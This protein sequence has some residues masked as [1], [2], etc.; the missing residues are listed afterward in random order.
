MLFAL[1]ALFGD[2]GCSVGP[3]LCGIV[4]DAAA[5]LPVLEQLSLSTGMGMEQ[6]ALKV[7]L[8]V[9]AIF[10]IAAAVV[11]RI[12]DKEGRKNCLYQNRN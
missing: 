11:I 2:V 8:L 4:S 12:L 7:G 3:W 10:P 1:L 6:L 9:I 5:K